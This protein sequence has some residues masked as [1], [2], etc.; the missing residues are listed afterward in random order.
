VDNTRRLPPALVEHA[1]AFLAEGR[2]P[3]V[4]KGAAT[5]ILLRDPG[6]Y[7]DQDREGRSPEVYLLRRHL[8]MAFAG[9]MFAFPGGTVDPRDSD[10]AVAW[11]GP[12]PAAWAERL[13]CDEPTAR[14]LVC[15][16]VRETFE[17]SSVLLAGPDQKSVVDDTTG[18]DW[19][20]DRAALVDR[21]LAFVDL[22]HRRG[23][24]LR[25]DL[26]GVWAHW[27]TPEFEPRRYDTRFFVAAMPAGQRTRDVSG[28][29]D[30]VAWM[31]PADALAGVDAG[32]MAMLPPTYVA[33]QQIGALPTVAAVWDAAQQR[34]VRTVTPGVEIVGDEGLLTLPPWAVE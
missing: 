29:A 12:S 3:V 4:P 16:A 2:T 22:L 14:A 8:G 32:T 9:G 1:R 30:H 17:E 18:D 27:I 19:E 28:E 21:T 34:V 6:E 10:R 7:G 13:S 5:V 11:A 15:A 26:L 31:R 23:L 33:L 24:V 25:T 20:H